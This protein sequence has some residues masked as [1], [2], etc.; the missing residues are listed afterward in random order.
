MMAFR[1]AASPTEELERFKQLQSVDPESAT[2]VVA[3]GKLLV[4]YAAKGEFRALQVCLE[5]ITEVQSSLKAHEHVQ[6][7]SS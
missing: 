7:S 3:N 6:T 4:D 2:N 1:C 5:H